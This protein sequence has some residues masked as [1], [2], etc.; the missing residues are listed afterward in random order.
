MKLRAVFGH[1]EGETYPV[2]IGAMDD[3]RWEII[4][5]IEWQ[6]IVQVWK[7]DWDRDWE[8]YDY[9]EAFIEFDPPAVLA[10]VLPASVEESR[11]ST[12][13]SG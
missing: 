11:Y 1:L 12:E 8:S 4:G 3:T 13:V 5:D 9:C 7:E 2:C 6:R 10:P